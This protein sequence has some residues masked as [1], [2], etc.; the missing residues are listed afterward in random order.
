LHVNGC[1]CEEPGDGRRFDLDRRGLEGA[2]LPGSGSGPNP[3]DVNSRLFLEVL[4]A[5]AIAVPRIGIDEEVIEVE[6]VPR[7]REPG[8]AQ[9]S[10]GDLHV[11]RG[12]PRR[13]GKIGG[14]IPSDVG[15]DAEC[16]RRRKDDVRCRRCAPSR[17]RARP[18]R[19]DVP[20]PAEA[21]SPRWKCVNG[22]HASS[23]MSSMNAST[24]PDPPSII[25][26]KPI[27]TT[28][29][30]EPRMIRPPEAGDGGPT[31]PPSSGCESQLFE[32]TP[33]M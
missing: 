21:R 17:V 27:A 12:R 28:N 15:P 6:R 7:A 1:G 32:S 8:R 22:S 33:Q 13:G 11:L 20:E 19:R 10:N 5:I 24:D 25:A 3:R 16:A 9:E 31:L 18:V 14:R 23:S 29:L 4:K 2:D 26:T 30:H